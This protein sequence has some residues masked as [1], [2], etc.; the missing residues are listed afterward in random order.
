M[1]RSNE[2]GLLKH[3]LNPG[4]LVSIRESSLVFKTETR[5]PRETIR[6]SDWKAPG[7]QFGLVEWVLWPWVFLQGPGG[8]WMIHGDNLTLVQSAPKGLRFLRKKD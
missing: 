6:S 1:P 2:W 5:D 3:K 8:G 4:D 7:F